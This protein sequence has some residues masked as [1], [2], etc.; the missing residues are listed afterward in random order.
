M[1]KK[2]FIYLIFVL[3]ININAQTEILE[4]QLKNAKYDTT[5]ARLWNKIAW[6]LK[7]SNPSKS[8]EYAENAIN[9][10]YK[11]NLIEE[12]SNGYK[13]KGHGFLI[14]KKFISGLQFYDSAI[15]YA[16]KSKN[17]NLIASTF[18]KKAGAMG[19]LGNIDM[20]IILYSQGLDA[21]LKTDNNLLKHVLCNNIADAF[22]MANRNTEQTQ[23]YFVQAI[24]YAIKNKD[25][26]G[27]ALSSAN[28]AK[29]YSI[30][31]QNEKAKIELKR[32]LELI[33][34]IKI[35][36]YLLGASNDVVS[37]VYEDIGELAL[38]KKY[39][40]ISYRIIDSLK[41][42]DNKL[43]PLLVLSSV[44]L[45][46]G[47][48]IESKRN[49]LLMLKISQE[50]NAKIYIKE[51]FRILAE[52]AKNENNFKEALTYFEKYK[53]WND[54]VFAIDREKNIAALEFKA[55]LVKKEI[56]AKLQLQ[57]KE[58]LNKKLSSD[59]FG[60]KIGIVVSIIG[61]VFLSI[62]GFV[63]YK[64]NKRKQQFNIELLAKNKLVEQQASEKEILIQEIHHR[65][66]NN[67]TM[68]QSLL[69]LQAK[70]TEQENV[71]LV[72]AESQTR[73]MSMALVHQHLYENDRE[74]SLDL[75]QFLNSLL[76]EISSTFNNNMHQN[77]EF[78]AN[79]FC[80]EIGIKIATPLGLIVNELI[81][82]SLKYAFNNTTQGI[83]NIQV[84]QTA[85]NIIIQYTDNGKGLP[86]PF[87][88][89]N[90]GFGFKIIKLLAKQIK[91]NVEYGYKANESTFTISILK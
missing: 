14:Q 21:A 60:L 24:E 63:L 48:I 88:D 11:F 36:D 90:N 37:S 1:T 4:L 34:K 2:I 89:E 41:M 55:N 80:N 6:D 51:S 5:K 56:E 75:V 66:K 79:G 46:L 74:G 64:S 8:L 47:N 77:I 7:Y 59:I 43:R 10:S 67:L 42:P 33:E 61:F 44:N 19:D 22:Q 16:Q 57:T 35:R 53:N 27:A 82:N 45:K 32:T 69:Y 29:E 87:T 30:H 73:I 28:L 13:A 62:L 50:R 85:N 17:L 91:A 84:S 23:K 68:L 54:S 52:I 18:N 15:Y 25:F 9:I 83:I 72:L 40:T 76:N 39:A 38:A 65:V 86:K 70:S 31:K 26:S 71:K 12:L 58:N 20:A 81:T 78:K 3:A 49:A